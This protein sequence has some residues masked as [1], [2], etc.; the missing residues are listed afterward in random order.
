MEGADDDA[1]ATVGSG[2]VVPDTARMARVKL[3]LASARGVDGIQ[4]LNQ[5][6]QSGTPITGVGN[7]AAS[8]CS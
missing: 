4:F 7:F 8:V 6:T 5:A 3:W 2:N 1:P